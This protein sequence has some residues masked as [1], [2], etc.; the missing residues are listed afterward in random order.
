MKPGQGTPVVEQ[1]HRGTEGRGRPPVSVRQPERPRQDQQHCPCGQ[2]Q[3]GAVLHRLR[4][5][6]KPM[7][8]TR[9]EGSSALRRVAST[10]CAEFCQ[11]PPRSTR[12]RQFSVYWGKVF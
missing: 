4:A 6:R 3:E 1:V 8:W 12:D 5:R 9:T 7:L 10:S 11:E 2:C